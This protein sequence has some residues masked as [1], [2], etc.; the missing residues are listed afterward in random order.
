MTFQHLDDDA[1]F[2]PDRDFA[3][4][5]RARGKVLRR[6]RRLSASA[7]G[8][9]VAVTG[10]LGAFA[11]L[12]DDERAVT[13]GPSTTPTSTLAGS[14]STGPGAGPLPE[15]LPTPQ[16][17]VLAL[18]DC[19]ELTA[20]ELDGT[21]GGQ[22]PSRQPVAVFLTKAG[23]DGPLGT[24]SGA[25]TDPT[26]LQNMEDDE[27]FT[28]Q[29]YAT[30]AYFWRSSEGRAVARLDTARMSR[31]VFD[32]LVESLTSPNAEL[33]SGFRRLPFEREGVRV[34]GT[35]CTA[36]DGF[37]GVEVVTG[38]LPARADYLLSLNAAY[39]DDSDA[40]ETVVIIA[41]AGA[42]EPVLV[43]VPEA[44]WPTLLA[45]SDPP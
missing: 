39:I 9:A 8:A 24:L 10:A 40:G 3:E 12:P 22:G 19:E 15:Q 11:V 23:L 31:P 28:E 2:V 1:V 21:T 16:A 33:P 30:G 37:Y 41:P 20:Y 13:S 6:R 36:P 4:R 29:P 18:V 42:P 7:A 5:V 32:A 38:D 44:D 35:S 14:D 34:R 17:R 43:P 26:S 25:V 45:N 27:V